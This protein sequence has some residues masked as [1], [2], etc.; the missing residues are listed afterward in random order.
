M[1]TDKPMCR[2]YES[3][4]D[5]VYTRL[6]A[7]HGDSKGTRLPGDQLHGRR[8]VSRRRQTVRTDVGPA[9]PRR[10][11]RVCPNCKSPVISYHA[12]ICSLCIGD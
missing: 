5:G 6:C 10:K 1:T 11:R 8:H 12:E 4:T 2:L 9:P 7:Y 3:K